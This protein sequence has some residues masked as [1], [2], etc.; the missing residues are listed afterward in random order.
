M[1]C[2]AVR[3]HESEVVFAHAVPVKGRDGDNFVAGLITADVEFMGHAK[4]ILKSDNEPALLASGQAAQLNI[5]CGVHKDG[6]K[7][8]SVSVEH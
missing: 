4:L 5:R 1:E 6:S 2:F 7:V 8:E 3:C